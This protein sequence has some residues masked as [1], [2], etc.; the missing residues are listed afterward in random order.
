[1]TMVTL[2]AEAPTTASK[3]VWN[4]K[5]KD[6]SADQASAC[7]LQL[8]RSNLEVRLQCIDAGNAVGA[9]KADPLEGRRDA[10]DAG[11]TSGEIDSQRAW[12]EI[13]KL[14]RL[15]ALL[16]NGAQLRQEIAA[17]ARGTG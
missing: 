11:R 17:R 7:M 4:W 15:S 12:D 9:S 6:N 13:Y 2:L 16:F 8:C 3:W 10:A 5:R 1:M 14:E